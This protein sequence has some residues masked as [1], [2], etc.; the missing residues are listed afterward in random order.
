M[1]QKPQ[2]GDRIGPIQSVLSPLRGL[3]HGRWFPMADAMGYSL[4]LLRSL[5]NLPCK[6]P[7]CALRPVETQKP[8][9]PAKWFVTVAPLFSAQ[10]DWTGLLNR[11]ESF[12]NRADPPASQ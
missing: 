6:K 12:P 9:A 3:A 11:A 2:R 10:P 1:K 4:P 8:I 5:A 7:R